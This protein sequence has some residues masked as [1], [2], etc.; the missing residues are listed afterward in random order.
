MQ[1]DVFYCDHMHADEQASPLTV[2]TP[3][4]LFDSRTLHLEWEL[5]ASLQLDL[6]SEPILPPAQRQE[7]RPPQNSRR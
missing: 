6:D 7:G 2:C 3:P 5:D 4:R 1:I